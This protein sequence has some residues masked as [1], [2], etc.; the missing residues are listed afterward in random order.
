MGKYL[1]RSVFC[2]KGISSH[3]LWVVGR[4]SCLGIYD[5]MEGLKVLF[6]YLSKIEPL[7]HYPL[8]PPPTCSAHC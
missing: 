6:K 8:S 5:P 1:Q 7:A 3:S 2:E 4:N